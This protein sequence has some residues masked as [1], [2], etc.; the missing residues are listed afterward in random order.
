MRTRGNP[1]RA[2]P[3]S[4][5][6]AC[7]DAPRQAVIPAGHAPLGIEGRRRDH[8]HVMPLGGQP[9]GQFTRILAD[10]CWDGREEDAVD[11]N[12]DSSPPRLSPS[13]HHV[14]LNR[15]TSRIEDRAIHAM[16]SEAVPAQPRDQIVRERLSLIQLYKRGF[17]VYVGELI[18]EGPAAHEDF[19]FVAL[20]IELEQRR[21]L[22]RLRIQAILKAHDGNLESTGLSCPRKHRLLASGDRQKGR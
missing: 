9:L 11:E 6:F 10:A 2:A 15:P 7:L 20:D 16:Q 12:S 19:Q 21:V 5:A 17:C 22:E 3:G 14:R 1:D 8:A 13:E 18:N 4:H